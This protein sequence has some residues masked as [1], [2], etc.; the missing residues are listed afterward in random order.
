MEGSEFGQDD[1]TEV[2]VVLMDMEMPVMDGNTATRMIRQA[3]VEGRL[4]RHVPILGISA[5][6]RSEQG[7]CR[8]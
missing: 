1:G 8:L 5:N 4:R 3:E 2:D 7:E 6:A